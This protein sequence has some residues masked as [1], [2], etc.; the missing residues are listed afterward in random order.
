MLTT[1]ELIEFLFVREGFRS[2]AYDDKQPWVTLEPGD[3]HKVTG[4][5]TVGYGSTF[6]RDD[7][8]LRP[9]RIG[10]TMTEPEA[11]DMAIWWVRKFIEPA[12]KTMINVPLKGHQYNA[13]GSFIYQYGE[14]AV[15]G[16]R[17]IKRINNK[18]RWQDIATEWINGTVFWMGKPAFWSRRV[19]ELFMYFGLNWRAA[20]NV[21][22]GTDVIQAIEE[23]AA[24]NASEPD[25]PAHNPVLEPATYKG[26]ADPTPEDGR[27]TTQDLNTIQ[28]A[29]MQGATPGD[30]PLSVNTKLP[31]QVPYGIKDPREVGMKP[32]RES[33]R[34]RGDLAADKGKEAAISGATIGG[35]TGA[36]STASVVTNYFDRFDMTTIIVSGLGFALILILFG[37]W[38]YWH[39]MNK[40]YKAEEDAQQALY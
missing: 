26:F 6:I 18:E 31:E 1:P 34:Y 29:I 15:S 21:P 35:V 28:L 14:E 24:D 11:R 40:A 22:V 16:W 27:I 2:H 9:V 30:K 39:G 3:D 7:G 4:K 19:G 10:D 13:L 5:L 12:L 37:L 20:Q 32:R 36:V 17:L 8:R 38:R 23:M 25:S 33:G